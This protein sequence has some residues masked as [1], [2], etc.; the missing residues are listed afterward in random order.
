MF[1]A[2]NYDIETYNH[3]M[4][5]RHGKTLGSKSKKVKKIYVVLHSSEL[6]CSFFVGFFKRVTTAVKSDMSYI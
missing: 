3:V 1:G 6:L 5:Q 4:L 2:G